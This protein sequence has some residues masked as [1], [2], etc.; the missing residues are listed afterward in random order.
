MMRGG[1]NRERALKGDIKK[2]NKNT[3]KTLGRLLE[4][5]KSYKLFLFFAVI[6]AILGTVFDIIGPLIMGNTTNYVIQSIRNQ[7]N[8]DYGEFM[9]FIYLLVGIY[10]FSALAEFVRF[11]MG[12]KV[13]VEVTYKLRE[14]I[15]KKLKRLP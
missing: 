5:L 11:R 7:G 4:Y 8:I 13:N 14:D 9:R 6:F 1:G 12:I 15:S 3:F 2:I 10:V